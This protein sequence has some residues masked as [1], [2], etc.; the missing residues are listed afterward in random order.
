MTHPH[1]AEEVAEFTNLFDNGHTIPTFGQIDWLTQALTDA[2]TAGREEG[3]DAKYLFTLNGIEIHAKPALGGNEE[4]IALVHQLIA[5]AL[6]AKSGF[7]LF[8]LPKQSNDTPSKGIN[9]TD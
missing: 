9:V 6:Y 7:N 4:T 3:R 5:E 1:I 8:P 2:F